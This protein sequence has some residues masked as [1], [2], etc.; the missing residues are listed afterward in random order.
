MLEPANE[1]RVLS[2][3]SKWQ[4]LMVSERLAIGREIRAIRIHSP[5]GLHLIHAN[6]NRT[7]ETNCR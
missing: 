3:D 6:A 4:S 7:Y 2:R 5:I 1:A